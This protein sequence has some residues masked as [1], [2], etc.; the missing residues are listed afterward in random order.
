MHG[1]AN[2]YTVWTHRSAKSIFGAGSHPINRNGKILCFDTEEEARAECDRLNARR[3]GSHERYSIEPAYVLP[4]ET[5]L[6][7]LADGFRQLAS[8]MHA[9]R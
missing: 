8:E 7:V 6:A 1:K 5:G 9:R 2:F 4:L 3:S